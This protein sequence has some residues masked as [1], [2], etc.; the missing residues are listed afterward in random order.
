MARRNELEKA[1]LQASNLDLKEQVVRFQ[2]DFECRLRFQ[3]RAKD[4][5][6][7]ARAVTEGEVGSV[8]S[9]RDRAVQAKREADML[10]RSRELAHAKELRE[11]Q[12]KWQQEK[13]LTHR[14]QAELS[15]ATMPSSSSSSAA[16]AAS[17][18]NSTESPHRPGGGHEDPSPRRRPHRPA[19]TACQT[20]AREHVVDGDS[21]HAAQTS[22]GSAG[23]AESKAST[24]A[25]ESSAAS[26]SLASSSLASSSPS[27][28]DNPL[29]FREAYV[30][31]SRKLAA[32][33]DE[34]AQARQVQ[35][36]LHAQVE[37]LRGQVCRLEEQLVAAAAAAARTTTRATTT[38][39]SGG[40]AGA[41][42]RSLGSALS[43]GRTVH[44]TVVGSVSILHNA[45]R[46]AA[47]SP[48]GGHEQK[49]A[50]D[51]RQHGDKDDK[52]DDNDDD[53]EEEEEEEDGSDD[54]PETF[55]ALLRE[56]MESMRAG[57][58]R[59]LAEMQSRI[60][61]LSRSQR[62]QSVNR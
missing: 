37:S 6:D 60:D 53:N 17:S 51:R 9:E 36:T 20:P 30:A 22:N 46:A 49:S 47:K 24:L 10:L 58:E 32:A 8:R 2:S 40:A 26:S 54:V 25:S 41:P 19:T 3:Q 15:A 56:E 62:R 18:S 16:S 52:D 50:A 12:A 29:L 14:L 39:I 55:E 44:G 11:L 21:G 33:N 34:L 27:S 48:F 59:R 13:D 4:E 42:T 35:S 28:A 45:S 57:Y 38:T 43:P 5:I 31:C 61:D 7:Q 1:R 23:S